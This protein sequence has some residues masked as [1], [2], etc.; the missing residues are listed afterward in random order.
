LTSFRSEPLPAD[1]AVA[2]ADAAPRLGPF[3]ESVSYFSTIGS[4]NDVAAHHAASGDHEGAVFVADAQ[5][6]GR[7]RRGRTWFS[8]PGAGLYVSTVLRPSRSR[9][10]ERAILLTTMAAGVAI[11][12]GVARATGLTPSLKW[13]ND[14][15]VEKRKLAGILAEGVG[16]FV[17]LGYGINISTAS[18]PSELGDRATSLEAELG[19]EHRRVDRARVFAETLASLASRY[20]DLLSARF[21]AILDA[22]RALAPGAHGARVSWTTPEGEKSGV[23]AGIDDRGALQV[24]AGDRI[25]R[26]VAG[27]LVWR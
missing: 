11:V 18:F 9:D 10:P 5:T 27:E 21:D 24:R 15:Y 17:V 1:F 20:D 22:W 23:T 13:P 3:C 4:T 14:L 6:S 19:W 12:E 16:A 8:P 26:I 2:V 25:E 7:G